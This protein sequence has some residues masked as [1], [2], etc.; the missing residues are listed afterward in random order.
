[1]FLCFDSLLQQFDY[2]KDSGCLFKIDALI[3]MW[4]YMCL[5]AIFTRYSFSFSNFIL[6]LGFSENLSYISLQFENRFH[7]I[8]FLIV[9]RLLPLFLWYKVRLSFIYFPVCLYC[10]IFICWGIRLIALLIVVFWYRFLY[11]FMVCS[12]SR[13]VLGSVMLKHSDISV[14]AVYGFL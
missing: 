3:E 2:K 1:M 5:L 4:F 13:H 12:S 11:T 10:L 9:L 6:C 14:L 7:T 8:F